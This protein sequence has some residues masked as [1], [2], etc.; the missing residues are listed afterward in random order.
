[1]TMPAPTAPARSRRH[2]LVVGLVALA[3]AAAACS[4]SGSSNSTTTTTTSAALPTT[5]SGPAPVLQTKTVSGVGSVLVNAQ[6]QVV[7]SF[8]KNGTAVACTSGCLAIWPAVTVPSGT[9]TPT[10]GPGVGTLGTTTA[11]G[12]TQVT[13]NGLPLFTY[14]GDTGPGVANGNNV[15]SFGGIWKVVKA[16]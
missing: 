3:V 12:P 9:T 15:N 2:L 14:A 16:S 8:T 10:G 11:N 6:G 13:V 7:Y 1:M 5:S 4:S